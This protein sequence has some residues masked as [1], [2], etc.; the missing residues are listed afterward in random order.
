MTA[1]R[2]VSHSTVSDANRTMD[3]TKGVHEGSS[4]RGLLYAVGGFVLIR[5]IVLG[6]AFTAPQDRDRPGTPEWWPDL[7]LLRWDSGHYYRIAVHGYPPAP[8]IT[9]TVA[10]FPAYPLLS[11]PLMAWLSPDVALVVVA[12]V[13]ALI[14]VCFLYAWARRHGDERA[15]LWCVILA[16][17]YPLAMFLSAAYA[18]GLLFMCVAMIIWLL[19]LRR[20]LLAACVSGLATATR[21]TGLAVAA[22]VV[23]WVAV[24]GP[25]GRWPRR[26]GHLVLVGCVSVS[27]FV[28]YQAYLWERYG[29]A[30]AFFAA[31]ASWPGSQVEHPWV[32]ALSLQ[33]VLEK[34]FRPIKYALRG[35]FDEAFAPH[36]WNP[37]FNLLILA[38]AIKGLIRPDRIPRVLFLLPVLIF[39][40]AYLPD[41]VTGS[42]LLGAAR[43]QLVALPCFLLLAKWRPL[44][45]YAVAL[46]ALTVALIVMQCHYIR[47]FSN[48]E[49]AG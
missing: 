33:P 47:M 9:D 17:A 19:D 32:R 40:M 41:P 31:Q 45:R 39:M 29:R 42:R 7:P 22:L 18:E 4:R 5:V 23:F 37:L 10:F 28:A 44:H 12:H 2:V 30:D 43:Y 48:A 8:H 15:A 20:Y 35:Q 24:Y 14:G 21:P 16:T 46:P 27:G 11:R 1:G 6:A 25:R 13:C 34:S 38:L 36:S 3:S 26:L 49:L